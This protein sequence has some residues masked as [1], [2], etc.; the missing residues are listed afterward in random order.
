VP[1]KVV[2]VPLKFFSSTILAAQ[3]MRI[4]WYRQVGGKW[5][6]NKWPFLFNI[7]N[8]RIGN[9]YIQNAFD[10]TDIIGLEIHLLWRMNRRE[11]DFGNRR[12]MFG[13]LDSHS[14][15]LVNKLPHTRLPHT[16][17]DSSR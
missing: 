12:H 16:R 15:R 4:S 11:D 9:N 14:Q 1:A 17:L 13:V 2:L 8:S 5:P 6:S 3:A 10:S 7:A